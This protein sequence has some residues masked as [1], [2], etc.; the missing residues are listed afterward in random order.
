ME[1]LKRIGKWSCFAILAFML[2]GCT[3]DILGGDRNVDP[4]TVDKPKQQAETIQMTL[5]YP[6]TDALH[7]FPVTIELTKDEKWL[8]KGLKE[9]AE[10]PKD[11]KLSQALP[12][13]NLIRCIRIE[14]EIA[15]VD[16]DEE[17]L[18]NTPKG[19]TIEQIIIQ[20]I[21]H[22]LVKNTAVKKVL[23]TINGKDRETL[24][25]HID[26]IDPIKPDVNWLEK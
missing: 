5:F 13:K 6:D 11:K 1:F 10:Q 24:L 26:I 3:S 18:K 17:V 14:N 15:Y 20:S 2:I 16:M 25:G 12:A 8:E 21:A 23:F 9:L 7:L 22:T 4:L 19:A